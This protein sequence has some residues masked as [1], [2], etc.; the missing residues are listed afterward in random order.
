MGSIASCGVIKTYIK[1]GNFE[2]WNDCNDLK[3]VCKRAS[4]GLG[5][6]F[7]LL[8]LPKMSLSEYF[9]YR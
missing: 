7:G 4:S 5:L 9:L 2:F 8:I 6:G 3:G 1:A